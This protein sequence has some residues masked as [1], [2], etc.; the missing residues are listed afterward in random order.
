MLDKAAAILVVDDMKMVRTSITRYLNT[1]GY[2]NILQAG[3]GNE[4]LKKIKDNKVDFIFM[5]LVMP[6]LSGD[7]ALKKL[8]ETDTAVPVVIVSSVADEKMQNECKALGMLGYVLKPLNHET[9]PKVLA[10]MLGK[11]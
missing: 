2:E 6:N 11:V 8:R 5:D 3:S 4:A 1:L 10:E 9:G 7:Q